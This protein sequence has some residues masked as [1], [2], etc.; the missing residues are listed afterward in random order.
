MRFSLGEIGGIEEHVPPCVPVQYVGQLDGHFNVGHAAGTKQG[1]PIF[2]PQALTFNMLRLLKF[3]TYSFQIS[4]G[5]TSLGSVVFRLAPLSQMPAG[6][7]PPG[8]VLPPP[9]R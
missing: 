1:D 7:L 6:L 4:S 5:E 2:V 3:G 8:A 9:T